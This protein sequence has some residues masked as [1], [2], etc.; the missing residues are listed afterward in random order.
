[1]NTGWVIFLS[2]GRPSYCA[3]KISKRP[4][5]LDPFVLALKNQIILSWFILQKVRYK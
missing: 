5:P 2:C 4:G 1:M 3:Q